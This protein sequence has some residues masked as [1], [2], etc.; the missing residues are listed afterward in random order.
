V[1]EVDSVW[2]TAR[3][4]SALTSERLTTSDFRVP[5]LATVDLSGRRVLETVSRGKHLLTRFD[6]DATLHS[7]LRMEGRW[8][9][10]PL[11]SSWRRPAHEARVVLRTEAH[12]AIGFTV[13]VDLVPTSAEG[14]LVGHLGP[15][16][17][18]PDW[19]A[20]EAVR[21]L[22]AAPDVPIG[23]ALLDQRNLAGIGNVYR[24]ELCFITGV[25]P[26][27]PVAQVPGL[28][29]MV[30]RAHALLVA[31]RDRSD[32]ITTGDRRPGRRLWVYRRRGPCLRCGTPIEIG[33]L[34]PE[35]QER[36]VWW[37]PSCQ[38]SS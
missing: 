19:D 17:L 18:G 5:S 20:E 21:R 11:G 36:T 37:C 24:A 1:P 2:Q 38:P 26:H 27:T 32:R 22:A 28:P 23:E 34:G 30:A 13:L 25:D 9:V 12:E 31:N 6:G 16:L 33:E 7:H 35:G 15:D 14:D 4:L 29:R 8:D 3:R 10:Q